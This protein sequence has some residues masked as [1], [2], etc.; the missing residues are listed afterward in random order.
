MLSNNQGLRGLW[1]YSLR[2][3]VGL[4]R[5]ALLVYL[6]YLESL[7]GGICSLERLLRGWIGTTSASSRGQGGV[8]SRDD[9]RRRRKYGVSNS[10]ADNPQMADSTSSAFLTENQFPKTNFR[11]Y[12]Y[13][14]LHAGASN[15][16]LIGTNPCDEKRGGDI[17]SDGN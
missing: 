10:T 1:E 5:G 13:T 11:I 15:S 17:V 12:S 9:R 7:G 2:Q 3:E 8:G 4:L 16:R 14:Q 6:L